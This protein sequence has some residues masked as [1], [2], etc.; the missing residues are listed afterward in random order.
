MYGYDG[1]F[2]SIYA[3]HQCLLVCL[4]C[5]SPSAKRP[6]KITAFATAPLLHSSPAHTQIHNTAILTDWVHFSISYGMWCCD[7]GGA[8]EEV[9]HVVAAV[10]DAKLLLNPFVVANAMRFNNVN[11]KEEEK[12]RGIYVCTMLGEQQGNGRVSSALNMQL[13]PLCTLYL[14]W[15]GNRYEKELLC[16]TGQDR[17]RRG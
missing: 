9:P 14:A 3:H 4:E 11:R 2:T 17:A 10:A 6:W 16:M 12:T 1:V 7:G 13:F 15:L 8:D 5:F